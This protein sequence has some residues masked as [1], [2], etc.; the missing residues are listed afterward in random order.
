[1]KSEKIFV[2][3]PSLPNIEEFKGLISKIWES[4]WLTNNGQFHEE[5]EQ[6]LRDYLNVDYLSLVSNGTL[7]LLIALKALNLKGEIIT[8]PFTF[9][10]TIN[11]IEWLGCTPVFCDIN[12]EDFNINVDK[13][14]SLITEKTIAIMPVH[15]YG[16]PCD[17]DK[18]MKI[19]DGYNLKLIYD[20]AHAFDIKDGNEEVLNYGDFS[21][22]SF[23]ATKAFNTIE[24]GAIISHKKADKE[25]IDQL[26]NFGY[27]TKDVI[28]S[29][30]IN[31][32]MNELQ[33]VFGLL[34]LNTFSKQIDKRKSIYNNYMLGLKG[35][36]GL[37]LPF[38]PDTLKHNYTYF[39]VRINK[40]FKLTRD[41]LANYLNRNNIYPRKYFYPL[42][43]NMMPY[44]SN[45]SGEPHLLP[46]ANKVAEEILC[47][48]LYEDLS[49]LD[50]DRIINLIKEVN[51]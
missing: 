10:A 4:K 26:R 30:G 47:L 21:A 3:Q 28:V 41:E 36:D 39:P 49:M 13:V 1:M 29:S 14:E 16:Y 42:V 27:N 37:K 43:S 15:V 34:Q 9:V 25:K 44:K 18:L 22:I 23:H 8:T 6:K 31:S 5:F 32:K 46:V 48:P 17:N 33:S 2:T 35:I 11:A 40:D 12:D 20:A 50:Q 7:A 19:V 24:G 38:I 45:K 51:V